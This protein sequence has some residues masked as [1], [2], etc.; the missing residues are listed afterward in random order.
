MSSV[1]AGGGFID[2]V[3]TIDGVQTV[4]QQFATFGKLIENLEPAWQAIGEELLQDFELQFTSEGGVFGEWDALADST[5]RD[6]E[7]KGY[8]GEGPMEV[9]TG[10]LKASVTQRGAP[11]NIFEVDGMTAA[12]GVESD[13]A[14]WQHYGTSRG[15]PARPL[16]GLSQYRKAAIV[17]EIDDWIKTQ[18]AAAGL[19]G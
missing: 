1:V 14:G 16:V 2:L 7:R 6:R 11:G 12:F 9:R 15:I 17:N 4:E 8:G 10:E 3:F 18:I 19:E 5:V 13:L